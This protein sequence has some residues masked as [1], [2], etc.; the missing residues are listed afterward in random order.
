MK[1]AALKCLTTVLPVL[2][3]SACSVS[4]TLPPLAQAQS[5]TLFELGAIQERTSLKAL[6]QAPGVSPLLA[7]MLDDPATQ[8]IQEVDV[9]ASTVS[10]D[11]KSL[12]VQLGEHK[13]IQY[14]M[15]NAD[16]PAPGMIGWVGDVATDR[17]QRFNSSSEMD[18]DPFNWV[19]LVREGDKVVG[20]LHVDGQLYRLDYIGNGRHVLIKVDESK[21]PPE[22]EPLAG[23]DSG[24]RD[25]TLGKRPQSAHSIIRVLL[26]SSI[27]TR[28]RNPNYRMGL[29]QALQDANLYMRNSRVAIT[30]ELAGFY[31][32]DYDET[33]RTYKQQ[34][35]D[36][37]L[38][39]PFGVDL[40]KVR[41]ALRADLVS[42]YSSGSEYCGLAWINAS[43]I[44]GHSVISCLGA[45]AH[46]MGHNL[47]GK[48]NWHEGDAVGNPP[49]AYGY[50]Y[51]SGSPRFSTQ[52]SYSCSPACPQIPYHSNPDVT[53]QNIPVGTAEHH[54]VARRFNER[55]ETV[56]NFYPPALNMKLIGS[57]KY[58]ELAHGLGS[59]TNIATECN[60]FANKKVVTIQI[61]N[62]PEGTRL[63]FTEGD[64]KWR[65]YLAKAFIP[66]LLVTPLLGR[67]GDYPNMDIEEGSEPMTG[68]LT[69]ISSSTAR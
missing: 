52:M 22:A 2:F 58:C 41:E 9:R 46:E 13:T 5:T 21:L 43:K 1:A 20:D 27:Q 49:Y 18:F 60:Y 47:G 67:P 14:Q 64:N 31:D 29:A 69:T 45:L 55:R 61:F 17:R 42:L 53:Y 62:V 24:K 6:K 48:H 50:R 19:S 54:N 7:T 11:A 4:S 32:A 37:R 56:E 34:L 8:S 63:L 3:V 59:K 44:Q 16:S 38:A 40:L 28:A 12:V 57:I 25:P 35:D 30:Y 51:I 36:M 66:E 26:V 15:R 33:G 23:L 65:S 10:A 68:M 39:K